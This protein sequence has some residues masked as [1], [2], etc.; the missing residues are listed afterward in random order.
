MASETSFCRFEWL[1]AFVVNAHEAP[2]RSSQVVGN[3]HP[4][5]YFR[6]TRDPTGALNDA[7]KH[8]LDYPQKK[9]QCSRWLGGRMVSKTEVEHLGEFGSRLLGPDHSI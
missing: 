9:L 7:P 2:N 4:K 3:P 1:L 5:P 8:V 6:V